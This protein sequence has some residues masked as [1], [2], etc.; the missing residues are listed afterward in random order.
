MTEIPASELAIAYTSSCTDVSDF[1][2]FSA[3]LRGPQNGGFA[4]F[5]N[6]PDY[7]VTLKRKWIKRKLIWPSL[8]ENIIR[9]CSLLLVCKSRYIRHYGKQHKKLSVIHLNLVHHVS[10]R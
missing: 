8:R 5:S 1:P 7:I 2:R 9:F 3:I 6:A 10:A 4:I